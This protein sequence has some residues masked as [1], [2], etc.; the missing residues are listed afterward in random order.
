MS[1]VKPLNGVKVLELSTYVA[2]PGCAKMLADWGADVI[3]IEPIFGDVYRFM[4]ASLGMPTL[5]NEN[6]CFDTE[7]ANKRF[8]SINL[9]SEEGMKI[10]QEL[11]KDTDVL[12]TNYR[13]DVLEKLGLTYEQ[14]KKINKGLVFGSLLGYGEHGPDRN[15]PG[16]DLTAFIARSGMMADFAD[17]DGSPLSII[18]AFGDH[19]TALSLVS[20][21]CAA[22]YKKAV[23]GEGEYVSTGLYQSAIYAFGTM[24]AGTHYAGTQYGG[25]NYP[26]SRKNPAIPLCNTYKTSDNEWMLL[27]ATDYKGYWPVVCKA[28]GAEE[29]IDDERFNTL[30]GMIKNKVELTAIFDGIFATKTAAEWDKI[31]TGADLPNEKLAHWKDVLVDPQAWDNNFLR[32]VQYETGSTAV[33]ANTPVN[34]GSITEYEF[35]PS[36]VIG[37]DTTEIL[38]EIGYSDEKINALR[39][40]KDI[41]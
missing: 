30:Q 23:T 31:L 21:I 6:P 13:L 25:L 36:G 7:N 4:G 20:G 18:A 10:L 38:K 14:L 26:V 40:S 28:L 32:K 19:E 12:I 11:V 34:F 39:E 17:K 2:A 33:V 35:K 16:F 41:K 15:K 22:L 24:I 27:S 9:K 8:L 5:P 37:A 3:K 1:N 29:L